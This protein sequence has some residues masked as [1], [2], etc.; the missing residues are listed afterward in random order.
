MRAKELSIPAPSCDWS[1]GAGPAWRRPGQWAS[2][3]PGHLH[4]TGRTPTAPS[5]DQPQSEPLIS[6]ILPDLSLLFPDGA[7]GKDAAVCGNASWVNPTD[8]PVANASILVYLQKDGTTKAL[9]TPLG[10]LDFGGG[11][12]AYAFCTDIYYERAYNRGFCLDTGFFSDWRVAWLVT[13]YPPTLN[14][15]IQQAA[16]QSAV[17]HLTDGWSLRQIDSTAYNNTGAQASVACWIDFNRNGSFHDAGER[18]A[19]VINSAP[20]AQSVSLIFSG[21]SVPKAGVSY[22]RCRIANNPQDVALSIGPAVS[23]EVEDYWITIVDVGACRPGG[24]TAAQGLADMPQ[25]AEVS[26]AGMTWVDSKADGS[27]DQEPL[28]S[29]VLLNIKDGTGQRVALV[30]TGPGSFSAG[31]YVMPNLPP[32]T[33]TVTVERWPAGYAPAAALSQRI[34]LINAGEQGELNFAFRRT[35]GPIYIPM[36]GR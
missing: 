2:A 13:N 5:P 21:F 33:Y 25:C 28:L 36:V 1:G 8:N 18:A 9:D 14:N 31:Q 30:T 35:A 26:L 11:N 32:D 22:L 34:T 4:P 19:S 16:R 6:P 3:G 10:K 12:I 27:F 24:R 7:D 17:W 29:G 15:A 23:G 20:V